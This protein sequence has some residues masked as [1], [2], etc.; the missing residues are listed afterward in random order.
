[1]VSKHLHRRAM[2]D[3][4]CKEC[5]GGVKLQIIR[6]SEDLLDGAAGY[7]VDQGSAVAKALAKDGVTEIRIGLIRPRNGK[8]LCHL[9]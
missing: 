3:H 8:A 2:R 7:G 4:P 6:T 9:T 5:D 1:M